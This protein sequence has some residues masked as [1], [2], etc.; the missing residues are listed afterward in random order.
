VILLA[1]LIAYFWHQRKRE[2]EA[3]ADYPRALLA[4]ADRGSSIANSSADSDEMRRMAWAV[5]QVSAKPNV[6]RDWTP[7][8]REELRKLLALAS[9]PF[10]IEEAGMARGTQRNAFTYRA[11]MRRLARLR[12]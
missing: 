6:W 11:V 8:H 5:F 7:G 9:S 12:D 4:L 2:D 1:A 3:L 10:L